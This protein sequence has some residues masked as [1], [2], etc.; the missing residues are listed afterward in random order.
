M[1]II[2]DLLKGAVIGIANIIPGVS[3]GTMLL[4]LGVYERFISAIQNISTDTIKA[5]LRI[6]TFKRSA[7]DEFREELKQVLNLNTNLP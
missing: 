5:F 2:K 6:F 7:F 4:V 1:Q 3:G